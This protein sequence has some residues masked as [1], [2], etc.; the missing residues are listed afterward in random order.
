MAYTS[1]KKGVNLSKEARFDI[2]DLTSI[3]QD[4]QGGIP[5]YKIFAVEVNVWV[6]PKVLEGAHVSVCLGLG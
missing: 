6:V 1:V 3:Q 2:P 4:I 5:E